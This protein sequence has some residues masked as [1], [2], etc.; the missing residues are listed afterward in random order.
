MES[1]ELKGAVHSWELVTALDGPG[2]R[3]VIFLS[4]CPLRCLYCQ[5]PDT[6]FKKWGTQVSVAE[7]SEK[8]K[9]Y[10]PMLKATGGGVTI[11]GGEP[12]MQPEF[13]N[14]LIDEA[15]KY[16]LHV[17]LDTS[18]Y[19]GSLFTDG[20]I[21]KIDLFLLDIKSGIESVY[22]KTVGR[23]LKPTLVFA[24]RLSKMNKKV[25]VRFVLVPDLTDDFDNVEK[26]AEYA[27][28]MGECVERVEILPFHQLGREKWENLHLVYQ[29]EDT[30][31]PTK[32]LIERVKNQFL[33]YNLPVLVA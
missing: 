12:M 21:D 7:L 5:N 3:L 19:L 8:M 10:A 26:V 6:R 18:G 9:R 13:L 17:A 30:K 33:S 20:D 25:W 27:K 1:N 2:T 11:T 31:P 29:L 4:G 24:E 15:K 22:K 14:A 32:D 23:P 28:S 16:D